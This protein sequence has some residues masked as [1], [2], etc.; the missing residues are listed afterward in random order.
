M[1]SL[2]QKNLRHS[3][4]SN[5]LSI[6][7]AQIQKLFTAARDENSS[8]LP[9]RAVL[10]LFEQSPSLWLIS[11]CHRSLRYLP[12]GSRLEPRW[13]GSRDRTWSWRKTV[14][15]WN[16]AVPQQRRG[17]K[18]P[19]TVGLGSAAAGE[20]PPHYVQYHANSAAGIQG[21]SQSH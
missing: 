13:M 16:K 11:H 20:E 12:R 7:L 3:A 14:A 8:V 15:G 17:L 1:L 5:L 9:Q 18:G 19:V 4:N 21:L 2:C 6:K 10:V